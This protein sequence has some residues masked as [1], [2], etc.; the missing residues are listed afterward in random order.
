M[1]VKLFFLTPLCV[2]TFHP[3]NR[4][5]WWVEKRLNIWYNYCYK[6]LLNQSDTNFTQWLVCDK[7]HVDFVNDFLKSHVK[8]DRIQIKITDGDKW[9]KPDVVIDQN[10]IYCVVRLD[11]DDMYRFDVIE[12]L[13]SKE[14]VTHLFDSNKRWVLFQDGYIYDI[15]N[16]VL[17]YYYFKSP[18]FFA[19]YYQPSEFAQKQDIKEPAHNLVIGYR[20]LIIS[21]KHYLITVH[22]DNTSTNMSSQY[23]YGQL[24][25]KDET[26]AVLTLFGIS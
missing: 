15:R 22:G 18:P 6:S 5:K 20:P 12:R 23:V 17:R 21:G 10:M 26:H 11:S 4:K 9:P 7:I 14:L 3:H 16:S 24:L 25:D 13:R 1:H 2:L 19:H 8:D